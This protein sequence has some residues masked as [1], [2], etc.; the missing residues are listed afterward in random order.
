MT[1]L[2]SVRGFEEVWRPVARPK[3]VADRGVLG[4]GGRGGE[5]DARLARI[6]ARAPEVI[7]KITGRTRDEAHLQAHLAYISREGSVPLHGRDGERLVGLGEA[8][9]LGSDWAAEDLRRRR[10][11]ALSLSVVLSMPPGTSLVGVRD[12]ASAFAAEVFGDRFDYV[13]ALH[14]DAGHPHVHLAVRMLGRD[15]ERLNPRKADLE[16][17]RQAFARALRDREIAAEATPRRARGIIRKPEVMPVRKLRERHEGGSGPP[18]RVLDAA[19]TEARHIAIG[20]LHLERPWERAIL[21]RQ[22]AVRRAYLDQ[23]A[24]LEGTGDAGSLILAR[25]VREFVEN[26]PPLSTRRNDLVRA[27]RGGA[28]HRTIAEVDVR[29]PPERSLRR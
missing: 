27:T 5:A 7:V 25:Q 16:H 11:A 23:A 20:E 21:E 29:S 13:F 9:E 1:D 24:M 12:A 8:G 14:S 6:V 26:M 19:R 28:S 15:G 10:D 22:R 17:W 4:G 18:P 3:R 2:M